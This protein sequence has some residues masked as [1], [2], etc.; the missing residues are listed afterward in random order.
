MTPR[1]FQSFMGALIRIGL[2]L[3][4][5]ILLMAENAQAQPGRAKTHLRPC[6]QPTGAWSPLCPRT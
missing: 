4:L 2:L 5:V 6:S 1:V 3:A